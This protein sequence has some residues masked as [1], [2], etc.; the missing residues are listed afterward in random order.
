M[1]EAPLGEFT[2]TR[3]ERVI[4]GPGKIDALGGELERRSLTRAVVVTGNTLGNFRLLGKSE[5]N[6][7]VAF[8]AQTV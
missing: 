4:S 2:L 3:L 6:A 5:P 1:L 7:H 8:D